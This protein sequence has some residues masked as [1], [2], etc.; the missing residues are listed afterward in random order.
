[1]ASLEPEPEPE[2]PH[3]AR[4]RREAVTAMAEPDD[5]VVM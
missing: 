4:I 1:V 3:P 2:L 5:R